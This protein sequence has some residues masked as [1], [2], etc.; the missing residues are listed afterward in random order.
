MKPSPKSV[1]DPFT[2]KRVK[3]KSAK[4]MMGNYPKAKLD[5]VNGLPP[6]AFVFNPYQSRNLLQVERDRRGCIE[7]AE[8]GSQRRADVANEAIGVTPNEAKALEVQSMFG[9]C[10]GVQMALKGELLP[11]K[12]KKKAK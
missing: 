8:L 6:K 1:I 3:I 9:D 4:V 7:L 5:R 2:G 11:S 10:P 12:S